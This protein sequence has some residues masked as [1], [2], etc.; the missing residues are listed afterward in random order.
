M[1]FLCDQNAV[2]TKNVQINV[3]MKDYGRS[4]KIV[5]PNID[6]FDD[7]GNVLKAFNKSNTLI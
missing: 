2:F 6:K 1:S 5:F 7:M 4:L 3:F